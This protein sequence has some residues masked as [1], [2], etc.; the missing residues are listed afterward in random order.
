MSLK[1]ITVVLFA[2]GAAL[3]TP[4]PHAKPAALDVTVMDEVGIPVPNAI[5]HANRARWIYT[6]PILRNLLVKTGFLDINYERWEMLGEWVT[7]NKGFVKLRFRSFGFPR[8]ISAV[9]NEYYTSR[10]PIKHEGDWRSPRLLPYPM[11]KTV[12]L[13]KIRNPIPLIVTAFHEFKWPGSLDEPIGFDMVRSDWMPPHG[14]GEHED[15]QF[16]ITLKSDVELSKNFGILTVSIIGENNG[17]VSILKKQMTPDSSLTFPNTAPLEGY[18][19]I[20]IIVDVLKSANDK[21]Q[22]HFFRI[23]TELDEH[24]NVVS[25]LYGRMEYI[26]NSIMGFK[27]LRFYYWLNPTPNDCNLEWDGKTN[28]FQDTT[29]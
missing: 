11:K 10:I 26:H 17:L 19:N 15:V 16:L 3:L 22:N 23:R 25:A 6:R 1:I 5:V 28:L 21:I 18:I 13:K 27:T 29:K 4:D 24:D 9:K 8:G 7:N 2:G 20:P 12:V 14:R